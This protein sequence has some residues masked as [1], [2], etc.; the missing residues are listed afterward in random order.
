MEAPWGDVIVLTPVGSAGIWRS[1]SVG[2][3]ALQRETAAK[4]AVSWVKRAIV[5][6]WTRV[7]KARANLLRSQALY[8]PRAQK[9]LGAIQRCIYLFSIVPLLPCMVQLGNQCANL[10]RLNL[11][12][13]RQLRHC[14][15]ALTDTHWSDSVHDWDD[16]K[17][18]HRSVE[19]R[20]L[21]ARHRWDAV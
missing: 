6:A 4:R 11:D 9:C 20:L 7:D 14:A 10:P 21:P 2:L 17:A 18:V 15:A 3:R 12:P 5:V 19:D 16:R 1:S 8:I 13:R